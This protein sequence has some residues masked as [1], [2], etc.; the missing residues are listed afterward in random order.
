MSG[1][2]RWISGSLQ[3]QIRL[4]RKFTVKER[5]FL[6]FL[7][8]SIIPLAIAAAVSFVYS[9]NDAMQKNE[10]SSMQ[11]IQQ[12]R[13]S[14]ELL[15]TNYEALLQAVANDDLIQSDMK[16]AAS[17]SK[18]QQYSLDDSIKKMLNAKL[19][20]NLAVEG[21]TVALLDN[22]YSMFAGSRM[23][24]PVYTNTTLYKQT[25]ADSKKG[26]TWLPPHLNE[27]EGF[28]QTGNKILSVS[29]PI[30]D[31]WRGTNFGMAALAISPSVFSH[32]FAG[33]AESE[34]G[35]VIIL[36]NAGTTVYS[37][38]PGEWG[39]PY[40]DAQ[41]AI[42]LRDDS[43]DKGRF[44]FKTADGK[45]YMVSF[46]K[47]KENGW[48]IV[49]QISYDYLLS[50]I[51]KINMFT[52]ALSISMMLLCGYVALLV[53]KSIFGSIYAL[54][55]SMRSLEKGDFQQAM[56]P[57]TGRDEIQ[58]LT[59]SYYR[60]VER[61]NDVINQLYR[62][63]LIKQEMQIKALKAQIN[64]HFL[65]NTLE[66]ISSLAKINGVQ[67]ISRM[68][69]W[70]SQI[71]HYS[72]AGEEDFVALRDEIRILEN[73]LKIIHVRFGD[74]MSFDIEIP[75]ELQGCTVLKLI[76]QPLVE[77]AVLHGIEPKL[78]P[79]SIR[80]RASQRGRLLHLSIEDDG[81]GMSSERL[82]ELNDML[83]AVEEQRHKSLNGIGLLNVKERLWLVYGQSSG[84]DISS[85]EGKGTVIE[86]SLP[87]SGQQ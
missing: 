83:A 51:R 52:I 4:L 40:Q 12:I 45:K 29:M 38:K 28:F 49:N 85:Q 15:M 53:F 11:L 80:I 66:T 10:S 8:I 78:E 62:E 48:T 14:T 13:V 60:M 86:I 36:D 5:L 69:T 75:E 47:M 57:D 18:L 21:I 35:N 64:P 70:L 41:L 72:I 42:S 59:A 19:I 17:F 9:Y 20:N 65:Y 37:D 26:F 3:W 25:I 67:P 54:M 81:V 46:T 27:V 63:K 55:Q 43:R 87:L 24:P 73:Y 22:E 31:R 79:G 44:D 61:L 39:E 34:Q 74:K 6:T 82:A 71:F 84:M 16:R 68:T 33:L 58:H 32:I 50:S 23:V 56:S 2:R 7:T 76:L 77:N 30:Q 1:I